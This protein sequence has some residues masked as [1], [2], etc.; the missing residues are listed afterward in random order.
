[1]SG[2]ENYNKI[3]W[4]ESRPKPRTVTI[5]DVEDSIP[6]ENDHP[7]LL[8]SKSR[9]HAGVIGHTSDIIVSGDGKRI[10]KNLGR[11]KSNEE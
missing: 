2:S 5:T 8:R 10:C 7:P 6:G 1:M 3:E 4:T 11:M 9:D